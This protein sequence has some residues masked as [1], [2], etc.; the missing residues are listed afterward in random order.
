MPCS[1][2]HYASRLNSG[3]ISRTSPPLSSGLLAISLVS[4]CV[5]WCSFFGFGCCICNRRSWDGF[6]QLLARARNLRRRHWL[7]VPAQ[8]QDFCRRGCF[9]S[10]VAQGGKKAARMCCTVPVIKSAHGKLQARQA[11][12]RITI[13][14]SRNR[15]VVPGFHVGSR[16]VS[17]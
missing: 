4:P 5:R 15:F 9:R 7:P 3:V 14:S 8:S 2:F 16:A 13:R 6:G 12:A 10:V 17:S 11:I 1:C